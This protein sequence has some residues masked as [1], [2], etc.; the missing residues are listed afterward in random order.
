MTKGRL[1]LAAVVAALI[2]AFVKKAGSHRASEWHGLTEAELRSKLDEKLP[3]RIPDE[4]RGAIAD[5]VVE[6]MRERGHI[7][8][9]EAAGDE[10][11]D[12]SEPVDLRE[13]AD[14]TTGVA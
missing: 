6:K 14:D 4:K 11:S 13:G 12:G 5:K 10:S 8:D 7:G 3:S 1:A 9:D 2:A